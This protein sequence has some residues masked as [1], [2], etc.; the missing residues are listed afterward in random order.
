MTKAS[1]ITVFY[2]GACPL[3]VREIGL[4]RKLARTGAIDF[5]DVS[6]PDAAPSCDIARTS[7]MARFHARL[8]NGSVVQG[9]QAFTEA[10]SKV[11]WLVWL[12]P[13]GR[14]MASRWLLDRVYDCFLKL[15]PGLQWLAG[16]R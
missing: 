5:E 12:R 4:L 3:C 8:T 7:L 1:R 14:N 16:K 6:P 2:D 10:W 13:L 15:R 11:P 9:A